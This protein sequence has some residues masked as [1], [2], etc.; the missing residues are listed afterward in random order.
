V[1]W[2]RTSV[3]SAAVLLAIAAAT[4]SA[5]DERPAAPPVETKFTPESKAA[6]ARMNAAMDRPVDR[7]L[8]S[9]KGDLDVTSAAGP[10]SVHF[11]F[12]APATF[13]TESTTWAGHGIVRAVLKAAMNGVAPI[14]GVPDVAETAKKDGVDLLVLSSRMPDGETNRTEYCLDAAGLPTSAANSRKRTV[15]GVER[16][17]SST[18]RFVWTKVGDKFRLSRLEFANARTTTTAATI[19]YQEF[20]AAAVPT[21]LMIELGG[22][23]RKYECRFKDLRLDDKKVELKFADDAWRAAAAAME[24]KV[25]ALLEVDRDALFDA[26]DHAQRRQL[27][28]LGRPAVPALLKVI[29]DF[30]FNSQGVM[31]SHAAEAL[32][33]LVVEEDVA[34]LARLMREE[35]RELELAFARLHSPEAVAACAGLIREG[36]FSTRLVWVVRNHLND[37]PVVEACC[38]WLA[39]PE[40][41]SG[42]K[43]W[44]IA[45]M[46]TA[47]AAFGSRPQPELRAILLKPLR[48]DARLAV[49][50]ALVRIGDKAAIPV[51]IET[52]A[53]P[54]DAPGARPDEGERHLA[55]E[56]L[57]AVSGD[58]TYFGH[59]VITDAQ[60]GQMKWTCNFAEVAKGFRA[61]WQKSKDALRFDPDT[62]TWSVK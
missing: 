48:S 51:L 50:G 11:E 37:P 40:Y 18:A 43:D 19:S 41:G 16:E 31:Q 4:S 28:A 3:V 49:A 21:L 33:E 7:G 42:D 9:M 61:W 8:T 62:R 27:V 29:C 39:A 20:G 13:A 57:N 23:E 58:R 30:E 56:L 15:N 44:A 60:H 38:A 6:L 10:A 52:F 47:A 12:A 54:V 14:D 59:S 25:R 53:T 24:A 17:E 26:P 32:A 22:G 45:T 2:A 46:A 55:G 34:M 1:T 36:C 35:H 5:Q